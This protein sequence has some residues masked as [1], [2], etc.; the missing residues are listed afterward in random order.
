MTLASILFPNGC[1]PVIDGAPTVCA[2]CGSKRLEPHKI[3]PGDQGESLTIQWTKHCY[4]CR[5]WNDGGNV[6]ANEIIWEFGR[7]RNYHTLVEFAGNGW[8]FYLYPDH[9]HFDICTPEQGAALILNALADDPDYAGI[10]VIG[11]QQ[12]IAE[13]LEA[14]R[15]ALIEAWV[16]PSD[17]DEPEPV[18]VEH[19]LGLF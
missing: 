11:G 2:K 9:Q 8:H 17:D 15:L 6:P 7:V 12:A 18:K 1:Q 16:E 5:Y 14:V 10:T 19:Q 4:D 3:W 13:A